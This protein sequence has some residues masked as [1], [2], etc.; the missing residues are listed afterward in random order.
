MSPRSEKFLAA[1][2]ALI[3]LGVY[4]YIFGYADRRIVFLYEHLGFTAY[5]PITV[6]RYW[7]AGLLLSGFLSLLYMLIRVVGRFTLISNHLSGM[8][9]LQYAFLPLIPGILLII[10][11]MGEPRLDISIAFSSLLALMVGLVIGFNLADHSMT[12]FR[13]LIQ[14]FLAS[15]GL[16]PFLL[17]FRALE[18][19]GKGF[20]AMPLAVLISVLSLAGGF[21]W[22]YLA[23]RLHQTNRLSKSLLI[24]CTLA[25]A[26]LGL[27]MAHFLVATPPG[28]PYITS[29][30]NFFAD[31]WTLRILT[32]VLLP[33]LVF[34]AAKLTPPKN[35]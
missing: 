7:M 27:P 34:T 13:R 9:I 35:P 14:H 10:T 8:K 21:L 17:L 26:Y 22:L 23:F 12:D 32:W 6:G 16:V 5:D 33:L 2:F 31:H 11:L 20:L 1:F 30:D 15:L 19:P 24:Q 29:S 3:A 18:L 28:I 25:I 4:G